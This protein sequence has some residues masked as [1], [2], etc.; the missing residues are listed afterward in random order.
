MVL[1]DYAASPI[2]ANNYVDNDLYYMISTVSTNRGNEESNIIQ[3]NNNHTIYIRKYL[4]K[5]GKLLCT[6]KVKVNFPKTYTSSV[7]AGYKLVWPTTDNNFGLPN[8]YP[9]TM[10]GEAKCIIYFDS[11]LASNDCFEHKNVN[12][13][14]SKSDLDTCVNGLATNGYTI[15]GTNYIGVQKAAYNIFSGSSSTT[16]AIENNLYN[17]NANIKVEYDDDDYGNYNTIGKYTEEIP[18]NNSI[19][20]LKPYDRKTTAKINGT[21]ANFNSANSWHYYTGSSSQILTI[22]QTVKYEINDYIYRYILKKDGYYDRSVNS[23]SQSFNYSTYKFS[24]V[25]HGNLP[26]STTAKYYTSADKSSESSG[27]SKALALKYMDIGGFGVSGTVDPNLNILTTNHRFVRNAFSEYKCDYFVTEPVT[28]NCLSSTVNSGMELRTCMLG[29]CDGNRHSCAEARRL[30]CTDST[31]VPDYKVSCQSGTTYAGNKILT[32]KCNG[33]SLCKELMC[34]EI[35][36]STGNKEKV[37]TDYVAEYI[38]NKKIDNIDLI[39]SNG[40]KTIYFKNLISSLEN[41]EICGNKSIIYREI[42]LDNPFPGQAIA[43]RKIGSGVFSK[44]NKSRVPGFNWNDV[45]L[46]KNKITKN[47]GTENDDIYID[48]K[49]MYQITLT[50]AKIKKIKEYNENVW[51]FE[52]DHEKEE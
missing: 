35:T 5:Y 42:D 47:S 17:L 24:D 26:I 39:D 49:P 40:K 27:T 41:T 12:G 43:L 36:C 44:N 52:F 37:I 3:G 45:D 25:R 31:Q 21:N 33:N 34:N 18:N 16:A 7:G 46:V 14:L 20:R 50:P 48:S 38:K 9:L 10:S 32:E 51:L 19:I 6:E 2:D 28:C 30:F 22:N 8:R 29:G 4:T 23:N 15:A 13:Y 11:V 1:N